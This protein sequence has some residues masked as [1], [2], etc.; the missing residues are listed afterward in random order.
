MNTTP[1]QTGQDTIP[2]EDAHQWS[3][4]ARQ[5]L[6]ILAVDNL[7]VSEEGLQLLKAVDQGLMTHDEAIEAT[8]QRAAHYASRQQR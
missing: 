8:L 7:V 1:L 4:S 2:K 5:A 3:W 6:A